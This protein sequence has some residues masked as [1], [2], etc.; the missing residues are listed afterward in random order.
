MSNVKLVGCAQR[1]L[2]ILALGGSRRSSGAGRCR[3]A[4]PDWQRWP[5][6]RSV[7]QTSPS[8]PMPSLHGGHDR[9]QGP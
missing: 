1:P 2:A 8:R 9:L 6:L 4:K 7:I 3:P 5:L